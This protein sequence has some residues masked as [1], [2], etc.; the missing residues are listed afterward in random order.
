MAV[1]RKVPT[2]I[3]AYMGKALISKKSI[4]AIILEKSQTLCGD[5]LDH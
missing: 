3:Q 1:G 5:C 4:L 2:I